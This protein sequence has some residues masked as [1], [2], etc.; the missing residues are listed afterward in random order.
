ME[1]VE[2]MITG[3]VQPWNVSKNALQIVSTPVVTTTINVSMPCC[4]YDYSRTSDK[5]LFNLRTTSQ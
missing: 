3:F 2:E 5:G 1:G 4:S